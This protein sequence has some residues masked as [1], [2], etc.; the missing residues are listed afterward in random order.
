M[1]CRHE[2]SPDESTVEKAVIDDFRLLE[3]GQ[4]IIAIHPTRMTHLKR[5]GPGWNYDQIRSGD[6]LLVLGWEERM[7]LLHVL[8]KG[9]R[10]MTPAIDERHFDLIVYNTHR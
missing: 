10:C 9:R 5:P 3:R 8:Y 1:A 6:V 7:S 2:H 4:I